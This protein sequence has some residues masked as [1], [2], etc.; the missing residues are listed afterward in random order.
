MWCGLG[1]VYYNFR[2]T[3]EAEAA[4]SKAVD[5]AGQLTNLDSKNSLLLCLELS[6]WDITQ[7]KLEEAEIVLQQTLTAALELS[8]FKMAA[9]A[10]QALGNVYCETGKYGMAEEAFLKSIEINTE[11]FEEESHSV[12]YAYLRLAYIYEKQGRLFEE[13]ESLHKNLSVTS[14]IYGE[15]SLQF[16]FSLG[17]LGGNYFFHKRYTEAEILLQQSINI[18]QQDDC[19]INTLP[20]GTC[21]LC[22][23]IIYEDLGQIP[24]AEKLYTNAAER[25]L[26]IKE[27]YP[28]TDIYFQLSYIYLLQNRLDETVAILLK[29]VSISVNFSKQNNR[30]SL[31]K[32]YNI[33]A[34]IYFKQRK[35]PECES[36]LS[37][38]IETVDQEKRERDQEYLQAHMILAVIYMFQGKLGD[39]EA[40]T[41]K[42]MQVSQLQESHQELLNFYCILAWIYFKQSRLPDTEFICVTAIDKMKLLPCFFGCFL[43]VNEILYDTYMCEERYADAG[44]IIL[45]TID[46]IQRE[47]G[48]QHEHFADAYYKLGQIYIQQCRLEEAESLLQVSFDI[49]TR[50]GERHKKQA[51]LAYRSLILVSDGFVG[52]GR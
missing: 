41:V 42:G 9:D 39:A 31:P 26:N 37:L 21:F 7:G 5:L 15:K 51:L 23:G 52:G 22:L 34:Q 35:L 10:F 6:D 36:C 28:I 32:I 24:E 44:R 27:A 46:A 8:E 40:L 29:V 48:D 20:L 17:L 4:H 11:L 30:F 13:T 12:G 47:P 38:L 49:F 3:T 25:L 33:L 19:E 16:A 43:K 18:S 1:N 45:S 2:N 14:K 50:L